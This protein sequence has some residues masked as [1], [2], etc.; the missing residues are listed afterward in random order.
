MK[1]GIGIGVNNTV[2]EV[3]VVVFYSFSNDFSNA[4]SKE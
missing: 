1:I 3:I 2:L 4:F